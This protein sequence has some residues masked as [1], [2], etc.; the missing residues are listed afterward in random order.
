MNIIKCVRGGEGRGATEEREK[1][2]E[3]GTDEERRT[4]GIIEDE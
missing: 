1:V 4:D 3:E 2:R